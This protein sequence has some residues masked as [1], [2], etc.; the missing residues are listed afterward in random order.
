MPT[1]VTKPRATDGADLALLRQCL[2]ALNQV[3][4]KRLQTFEGLPTSTYDLAAKVS[5]RLMEVDEAEDGPAAVFRTTRRK[6]DLQTADLLT[7]ALEHLEQANIVWKE[8]ASA[9]ATLRVI[10]DVKSYVTRIDRNLKAH[11]GD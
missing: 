7:G 6:T 5:A 11:I 9:A 10:E 4:N 3:P 8:G 2:H 1:P